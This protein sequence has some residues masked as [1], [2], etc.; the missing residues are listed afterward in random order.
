LRRGDGLIGAR[1]L[2]TG[3]SGGVGTFAVQ[4]AAAGGAEVIAL[5]GTHRSRTTPESAAAADFDYCNRRGKRASADAVAALLQVVQGTSAGV[6]G[7]RARLR[8]KAGVV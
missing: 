5:T 3:A 2:I 4:L 8:V 6:G 1:V 7:R